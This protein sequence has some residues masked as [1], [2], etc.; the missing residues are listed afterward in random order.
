MN[1]IEQ[2]K[3][4]TKRKEDADRSYKKLGWFRLYQYEWKKEAYQDQYSLWHEAYI[5]NNEVSVRVIDT[6]FF[7]SWGTTMI[8]AIAEDKEGKQYIYQPD[9]T[10]MGNDYWGGNGHYDWHRF[11]FRLTIRKDGTRLL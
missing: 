10:S 4:L 3:E 8:G 11:P 7:E 1:V 9:A 2:A 5:V 6:F